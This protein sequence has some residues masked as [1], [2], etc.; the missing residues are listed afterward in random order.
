MTESWSRNREGAW[1]TAVAIGIVVAVRQWSF[2]SV[3]VGIVLD[4]FLLGVVYALM[5]T[6]H[7]MPDHRLGQVTVRSAVIVTSVVAVAAFTTI[8][9]P[10]TLLGLALALLTSPTARRM[11]DDRRTGATPLPKQRGPRR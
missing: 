8:S 6:L 5:A 3:V 10:L 7:A 4:T 1:L 11:R 9:V 2:S